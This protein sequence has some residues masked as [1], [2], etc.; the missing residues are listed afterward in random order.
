[1]G[2]LQRI[3]PP[4]IYDRFVNL[5]NG[6]LPLKNHGWKGNFKSWQDAQKASKGY[7]SDAILQKVRQSSLSVKNGDFAYER[8][9]VLF[10]NI[11]YNWPLLSALLQSMATHNG[12]LK[13]VDFGGSL[14]ST[15]RAYKDILLKSG[16]VT[17]VV[18]EQK[19]FVDVGKKE[20]E[21]DHLKFEYSLQK[22]VEKFHPNTIL[23]SSVLQYL[24]S[25]YELVN[26]IKQYSFNKIII[27]RT[28]FIDDNERITVQQVPEEIYTASYPCRFFNEK[29]FIAALSGQYEI[30]FDF[31]S[32]CDPKFTADDG[33]KLYWKGF[34]LNQ[35]R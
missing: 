6:S 24:D 22:A 33:K 9:S 11:Q 7:D 29:D 21:D 20:F 26:E 3:L 12:E 32:F 34:Y 16:K 2:R 1:M 4:F 8:D 15:Y 19:H 25:P 23:L 17:W 35:K 27:D 31:D 13:I 30:M 10:A 28:A 14:G 18:V 5:N